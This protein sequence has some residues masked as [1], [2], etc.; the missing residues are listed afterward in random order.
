LLPA[1]AVFSALGY[2]FMTNFFPARKV[3]TGAALVI[4]ISYFSV[5]HATP[6][7]LREAHANGDT[8]MAFEQALA[9]QLKKLPPSATLMMDCGAHSGAVQLAGIP[10]RR[11]LRES[12]PPYWEQALAHP[13]QSADYI[14]AFPGDS[15]AHAVKQF[16]EGLE[17]VAT[18]GTPLGSGAVIYR[19]MR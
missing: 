7:C 17:R 10:F 6:I 11:V 14:I 12:N 3:M 18:V 5:W 2:Q 15:V 19:A 16:P 1:I 4:A 13:A 9:A 8:R